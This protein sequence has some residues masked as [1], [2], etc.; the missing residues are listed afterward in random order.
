VMCLV[1]LAILTGNLGR[2]GSGINP[3]RGQNNVQ[4]SAQMGCEP[5]SLTG[6]VPLAAN[7]ERFELAWQTPLPQ[8]PGLNLLQMMDAARNGAF[9]ALWAIGYDVLLTNANTHTTRAALRQLEC[10]V[11]QDLFLNKTAE[12]FGT[13]FLPASSSFEKDGTFMN[14]ERRIQRVRKVIEPIGQA[15]SDWE[16]VCHIAR[17]MGA[18]KAFA[19]SSAEEIW[20][21]VRTVWK[22]VAGIS[23]SRI[24]H[25]GLHWPCPTEDHPGTRVLHGESFPSGKRAALQRIDHRPSREAVSEE[26]PFLLIT[27]RNLYHFNA[28]TMTYRTQNAF[29]HRH[30]F[31]EISPQDTSR[32]G[33][34]DGDL[35]KVYSRHGEAILVARVNS[36]MRQGELFCTFHEPATFVNHVTGPERDSIVDTPEYKVTAVH[37]EKNHPEVELPLLGAA[38][39]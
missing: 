32:L 2:P 33:L 31:L 12:E 1:N 34:G 35:V 4:G 21:E 22:A 10:V 19:F 16:I 20:N 36:D 18:E 27:G 29:L 17:A 8:Q 15:K 39:G 24:E 28:G 14:A 11:V 7:W 37:V 30:D 9:K 5:N 26:F 3:L 23:Y 13:V 38:D 6:Y 25:G